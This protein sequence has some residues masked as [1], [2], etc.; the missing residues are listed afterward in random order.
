MMLDNS[1]T[2]FIN[3]ELEII[4][5]YGQEHM[6]W[7]EQNIESKLKGLSLL[8]EITDNGWVRIHIESNQFACYS[9][10]PEYLRRAREQIIM[11]M[12]RN[13]KCTEIAIEHPSHYESFVITDSS[14]YDNPYNFMKKLR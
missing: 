6:R 2:Y 9:G 7:C 13:P 11:L 8:R 3:P 14:D 1:F 5:L 10:K 4:N 12:M